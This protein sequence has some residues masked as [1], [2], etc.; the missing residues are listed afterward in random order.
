[1]Q[2]NQKSKTKGK[3]KTNPSP[4]HVK[5]KKHE[6]KELNRQNRREGKKETQEENTSTLRKFL[7]KF[8]T[9][10]CEKQYAQAHKDLENIVEAKLE[11]KIKASA[12]KASKEKKHKNVSK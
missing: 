10:L 9:N 12:A 6:R 5:P 1:M 4:S 11:R 2:S 3:I 8:L 7:S